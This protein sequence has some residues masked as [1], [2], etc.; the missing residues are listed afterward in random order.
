MLLGYIDCSKESIEF[1][2]TKMGKGRAVVLVV[3]GADEA[4]EAHPGRNTLTLAKRK[5]FVREALKTGAHLVP[6]YS[7]GEND[8]FNQ[9]IKFL[10]T[11]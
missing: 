9:V 7:F 1:V 10:Q 6:I 4:L 5:G 3:G 2:L 11:F 8:I